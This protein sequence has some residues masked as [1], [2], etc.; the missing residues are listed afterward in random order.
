MA[1]S[2]HN[3]NNIVQYHYL[4]CRVAFTVHTHSQETPKCLFC[5]SQNRSQLLSSRRKKTNTEEKRGNHT[6]SRNFATHINS[7]N[8]KCRHIYCTR[9]AEQHIQLDSFLPSKKLKL[10]RLRLLLLSF[11]LRK[12]SHD[13]L[14]VVCLYYFQNGYNKTRTINLKGEKVGKGTINFS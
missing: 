12:R 9:G 7:H 10:K 4:V 3:N 5:Q 6:R 1:C 11:I 8:S 14:V 13:Q 2:T